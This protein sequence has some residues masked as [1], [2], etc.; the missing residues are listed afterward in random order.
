MTEQKDTHIH[1]NRQP[2]VEIEGPVTSMRWM[3]RIGF[4]DVATPL[5]THQ[6]VIRDSLLGDAY[7]PLRDNLKHG[8]ILNAVGFW[9]QMPSG[10]WTVEAWTAEIVSREVSADGNTSEQEIRKRKEEVKR[11]DVDSDILIQRVNEYTAVFAAARLGVARK[12][13]Q[14]GYLGDIEVAADI[15]AARVLDSHIVNPMVKAPV[16]EGL[17]RFINYHNQE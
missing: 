17:E 10:T 6:V 5:L 4:A 1:I 2:P 12:L 15:V 16:K 9:K 7:H 8:D 14:Y 3:G 11:A 13:K